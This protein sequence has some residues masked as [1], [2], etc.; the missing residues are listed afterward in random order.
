MAERVV[1]DKQGDGVRLQSF[2]WRSEP[3]SSPLTGRS[4]R[5][6]VGRDKNGAYHLASRTGRMGGERDS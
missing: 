2:V 6:V 1:R 4:I 3:S 5:C